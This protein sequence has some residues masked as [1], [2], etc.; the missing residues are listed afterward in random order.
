MVDGGGTLGELVQAG[1]V[2]VEQRGHLVD[3][4]ARTTSAGAVHALLDA[5]VEVDDLGV[6]AAEL[7]CHVRLGN[8]GLHGALARDDLLHELK[9]EPLR[10]EQAAGACNGTGH[11]RLGKHR[12]RLHEEVAG[13]GAHVG[14]V[15]LVLGIDDLVVIVQHG[16]FDGGGTHVD[17]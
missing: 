12:G 1:G 13:A 4:R 14:V 17:A 8:H 5:L 10:K 3:E 15:P 9:T 2:G 11:L 7:N 6:L 16:E